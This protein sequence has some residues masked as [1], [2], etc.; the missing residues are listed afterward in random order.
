MRLRGFVMALMT[1]CAVLAVGSQARG[2]ESQPAPSPQ[3]QSRST[4][5]SMQRKMPGMLLPPGLPRM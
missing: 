4:A 1:L 3:T 5:P 2:Q